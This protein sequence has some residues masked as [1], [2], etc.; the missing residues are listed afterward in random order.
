MCAQLPFIGVESR[1]E[2][3]SVGIRLKEGSRG[4]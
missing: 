1:N 3:G 4:F 2:L